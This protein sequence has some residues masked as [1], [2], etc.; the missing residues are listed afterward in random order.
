MKRAFPWLAALLAQSCIHI[1]M[2]AQAATVEGVIRTSGRIADL[3]IYLVPPGP[4]EPPAPQISPFIEHKTTKQYFSNP[5]LILSS[6]QELSQLFHFY[7][8]NRK[9]PL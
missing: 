5:N 2:A 9:R 8:E 4:F 3:V 6:L 7:E 1:P